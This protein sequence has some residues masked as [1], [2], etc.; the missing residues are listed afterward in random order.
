MKGLE[1]FLK[2]EGRPAYTGVSSGD[3]VGSSDGVGSGGGEAVFSLEAARG[4]V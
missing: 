1:P 4:L 2:S 3:E